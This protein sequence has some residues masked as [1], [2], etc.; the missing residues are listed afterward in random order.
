MRQIQSMTV[1]AAM[2]AA[3]ILFTGGPAATAEVPFITSQQ[4]GEWLAHRL[5]GTKVLNSK[6]EIIGEVADVVLDQSGKAQAVVIS[7]G[8]FLGLGSKEVAVPYSAIR[9]GEVVEGSRLVVL[10]VTEAQLQAAA[11]YKAT[12]PT[13]ADR[14]KKKAADWAKIAKER[15]IELGHQASEK[16]KEIR[17]K[18]SAPE[19][20]PSKRSD[21]T[22]K[23]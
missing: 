6:G 12:D 1:L 14:L 22:A 11:A 5:S 2:I 20:N 18:M 10:D 17:E 3:S 21:G 19:E 7:L 16:A 8:G 13:E 15:A 4:S 23:Q 9:L